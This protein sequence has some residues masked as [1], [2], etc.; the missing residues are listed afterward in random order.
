MKNFIILS[1]ALASMFLLSACEDKAERRAQ[2]EAQLPAAARQASHCL[3][4]F[5][6]KSIDYDVS[7]NE[8]ARIMAEGEAKCKDL[9]DKANAI[10]AE[11]DKLNGVKR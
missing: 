9:I 11:L 8:A 4:P 10:Q 5:I 3:S 2:L 7:K 6:Y 1:A